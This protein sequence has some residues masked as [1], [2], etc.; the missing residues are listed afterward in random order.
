METRDV[1][2]DTIKDMAHARVVINSLQRRSDRNFQALLLA[3]ARVYDLEYAGQ[4]KP[5]EMELKARVIFLEGELKKAVF[6]RD[7][8]KTLYAEAKNG[9]KDGQV[10]V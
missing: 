9:G 3:Q 5:S 7:K 4:P 6:E 2:M 10:A 1:R 8:F